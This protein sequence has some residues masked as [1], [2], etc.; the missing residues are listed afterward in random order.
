MKVD[1][2]K[3]YKYKVAAIYK[4]NKV[5]D[6]TKKITA[7]IPLEASAMSYRR[8]ASRKVKISW[9]RGRGARRF[10][11]LKKGPKGGFKKLAS[12]KKTSY[13]DGK[14]RVGKKYKYKIISV[15]ENDK[16]R[17][18]GRGSLISVLLV[19]QVGVG[20]QKY[21]YSEM[22]E[23]IAELQ[24]LYGSHF[25]CNVAGKSV[26]GRNIYD[27]VIGNQY[28]GK[29]ILVV[30]TLH[31][32]EYM[33]SQLCM[34]Q[35]EYY[36]QNYYEKFGNVKI[37][38]VLDNVAIHYV[39][40]ANPDGVA[41]SQ[42]GFS[43]IRSEKLRKGFKKMWGTQYPSLWKANAR[44]VDLNKNFPYAYIPD[45]GKRG[46]E[47]Y[48]GKKKCSEPETQ[49]INRLINRLN[50]TTDLIGQINYHATGSIIFGE[51]SGPLEPVITEMYN[52]ARD[53]T[54]YSSAASY[55]GDS[56]S[57][58]NLREYVM[59]NKNVPS[60]TIEVGTVSCPLPA[61]Q[62]GGIWEKNRMLVLKEANLLL[63]LGRAGA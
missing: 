5:F 57:V 32:R 30:S 50:D 47:G 6:R 43:A 13:Q 1:A 29:S 31:A 10:L 25:H 7:C 49:T 11:V 48:T 51:C 36:L 55:S 62:F 58:G 14:V 37:S 59:Y 61:S 20:H 23:D 8:T 54:G 35:I 2:G 39:P 26:D 16:V 18:D 3:Y 24:R 27:V 38:N 21:S 45:R 56:K 44:G 63:S 12:V 28:A 17:L 19:N 33:A 41:I 9:Q 40:M 4:K 53:V 60:I 52:L 34:K 15:Y 22:S 46:R 42:Y